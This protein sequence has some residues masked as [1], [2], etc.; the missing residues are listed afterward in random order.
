MARENYRELA[1]DAYGALG[2]L[3]KL[4][5]KCSLEP[6]L[7]HL[8]YLRVSQINGCAYCVDAHSYEAL[9]DGEKPQRLYSLVTWRETPFFTPR[10]Q[11]ALSW[12]E[13]MT[14]LPAGPVSEEAHEEARKPFSEKEFIDLTFVIATINALNRIGVGFRGQPSLRA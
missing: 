12:A 1:A 11:A 7:V 4:M 10:E 2:Q 6:G 14:R 8:V 13:T 9:A 5:H 3:N